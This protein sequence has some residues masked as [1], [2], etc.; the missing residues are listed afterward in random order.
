MQSIDHLVHEQRYI[1]AIGEKPEIN[2]DPKSRLSRVIGD[3]VGVEPVNES[4]EHERMLSFQLDDAA[5]RFCPC[6]L[7]RSLKVTGVEGQK[8][9]MDTEDLLIVLAA[10]FDGGYVAISRAVPMSVCR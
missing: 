1:A 5:A 3:L 4:L 9:L 7:K 2:D 8:S 10:D 6:I